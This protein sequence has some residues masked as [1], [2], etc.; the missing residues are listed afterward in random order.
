MHYSVTLTPEVE[1]TYIVGYKEL[2]KYIRENAIDKISEADAKKLAWATVKFTVNE[3]GKS[4]NPQL[5]KSSGNSKID[6]LLLDV[7]HKM[8]KWTPAQ[9]LK[10]TKVKQEF[11]L[12]LGNN[13]C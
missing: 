9:N 5:K 11:V 12:G 1:A 7:I 4:T 6:K 13:G 2:A 3:E 8:P 10:G